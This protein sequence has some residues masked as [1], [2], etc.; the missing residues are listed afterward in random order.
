MGKQ[1][2]EPSDATDAAQANKCRG[3]HGEQANAPNR[4][5]AA[6]QAIDSGGSDE[7]QARVPRRAAAVALEDM[8]SEA[9]V[10]ST[11]SRSGRE[12]EKGKYWGTCDNVLEMLR[13]VD[14]V[15]KDERRRLG[16]PGQ[17]VQASL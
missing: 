14:H 13:C 3:S 7:S 4:A 8:P 2:K 9:V 17:R 6:V 1:S 12:Y 5:A 10:A 11:L 15:V 16:S